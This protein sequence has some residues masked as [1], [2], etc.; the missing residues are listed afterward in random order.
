MDL[1]ELLRTASENKEPEK[2]PE[3]KEL[4]AEVWP[5]MLAACLVINVPLLILDRFS[6][7]SIIGSLFILLIAGIWTYIAC[8]GWRDDK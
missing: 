4:F 5:W 2:K 1:E 7:R 6:R 8:T 3:P